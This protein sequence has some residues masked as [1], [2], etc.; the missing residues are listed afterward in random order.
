MNILFLVFLL[1]ILIIV[2]A[3]VGVVWFV[4]ISN[5]K[6]GGSSLN[7]NSI[8]NTPAQTTTNTS[9][10]KVCPNCNTPISDGI[11]FCMMCGTK[12]K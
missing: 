1:L 7:S 11:S 10:E 5:K 4:F 2:I 12:V 3:L 9:N 6:K 8:Y